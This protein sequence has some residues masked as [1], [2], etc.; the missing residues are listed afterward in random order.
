MSE[1]L[2]AARLADNEVGAFDN[3]V[4]N[5]QGL[6]MFINVKQRQKGKLHAI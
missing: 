5:S 4:L 3:D 2:I 1:V 6:D